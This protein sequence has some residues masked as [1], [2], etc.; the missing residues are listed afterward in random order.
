MVPLSNKL[1]YKP[2]FHYRSHKPYSYGSYWH[3]HF[4]LPK[5]RPSFITVLRVQQH[6]KKTTRKQHTNKKKQEKTTNK[7]TEEH[8]GFVLLFLLLFLFFVFC[9]FLVTLPVE[10]FFGDSVFFARINFLCST[11]GHNSM[12]YG[13]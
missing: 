11:R 1:V 7:K 10:F 8:A 2:H 3:Q 12:V 9:F 6:R 5:M 4:S 13:I